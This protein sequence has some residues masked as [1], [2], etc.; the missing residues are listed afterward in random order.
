MSAAYDVLND[1][2]KREAYDEV[3][4]L[5]PMAGGFGGPRPGAG[6]AGGFQTGFNQMGQM[7]DLGGLLGNFFGKRH[8]A[9][10]R[11]RKGADL[12]TRTAS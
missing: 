7:G 4:R 2:K 10:A 8:Q 11:A 6:D 9:Q 12:E 1:A 5:G 3:R